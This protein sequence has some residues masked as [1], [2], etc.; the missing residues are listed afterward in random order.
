MVTVG[1]FLHRITLLSPQRDPSETVAAMVDT[2][3]T[4]TW[5]PET[6][7]RDLG[8]EPDHRRTF[9]LAD[10]SRV[11]RDMAEMTVSLDDQARATLVVFAPEGVRPILGAYTL[12][13]F[14]L[15]A[16]V[17]NRRLVPAENYALLVE[18]FP[19]AGG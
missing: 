1:T 17:T 14:S 11:N 16:D 18:E 10:G 12:K 5:V 19:N 4:F 2:G 7:L 6:I 8:V 9:V 15:A 3:L 13:S